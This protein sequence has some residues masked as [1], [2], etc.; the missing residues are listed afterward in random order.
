MDYPIYMHNQ[1]PWQVSNLYSYCNKNNYPLY[2][3][4]KNNYISSTESIQ[5]P[6]NNEDSF[7][8]FVSVPLTTAKS[9]E[10]KYFSGVA[11]DIYFG[12]GTKGWGRLYN[13]PDSG[14]NLFLNVWTL[15]DIFTTSYKAQIWFNSTPPGII[16]ESKFLTTTNTAIS[17]LPQPKCRVQYGIMAKGFPSGGVFA[18]G[19]SGSAGTT[20]AEELQGRQIFPPGGSFTVFLYNPENP[21]IPALGTVSFGWWEEPI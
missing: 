17:P 12:E 21:T 16:Q 4:S 2:P 10:G 14:V 11:T 15:G 7:K 13:P 19:Y 1:K 18:F 6:K 9:F 20:V 8:Y 3:V 5:L